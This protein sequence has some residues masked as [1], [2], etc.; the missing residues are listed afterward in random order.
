MEAIQPA[1]RRA[2]HDKGHGEAISTRPRATSEIRSGT[3]V[4]GV[5]ENRS[6]ANLPR[7]FESMLKTTTE[8][9]DI[10]LFSIKPSRVPQPLGTPRRNKGNYN[11]SEQ[12]KPRHNFQPYGVPAVDDRRRLPSYTRDASSEVISMY[13]TASQKSGSRVFD[14]PDYRSYSLTQT[15]YSSY[16]LSNHRSYASLRSQADVSNPVQRPRSPFAYPARLKRPGFRP[17]SPALTD[18]GLVDYSRRAEIERI[19]QHGSGHSTSSP[20]SLYAQRRRPHQPL[21]P[22]ANRSTPSILSQSSPNRRS[23]SPLV[24]LRNGASSHDWPRRAGPA[25]VNTSPARSTFSLASTV[26]LYANVQPRSTTTTPGK[27]PPPSPLYYDYTEDFEVEVYSESEAP[28]PPPQFRI[29]KTIPEERPMSSEGRPTGELSQQESGSN[30]FQPFTAAEVVSR[31]SS[32]RTSS[33]GVPKPKP[34]P[35][36]LRE[37]VFAVEMTPVEVETVALPADDLQDRKSVRLSGLGYGAQQLGN[38]VDEVLRLFPDSILKITNPKKNNRHAVVDLGNGKS[39]EESLE[40]FIE[41]KSARTSHSTIIN[42][43]SFPPPPKSHTIVETKLPVISGLDQSISGPSVAT[44]RPHEAFPS[45][46]EQSEIRCGQT[47]FT[48]KNFTSGTEV[49]GPGASSSIEGGP[50]GGINTS[51]SRSRSAEV[52][53]LSSTLPPARRTPIVSPTIPENLGFREAGTDRNPVPPLSLQSGRNAGEVQAMSQVQPL[54]RNQYYSGNRRMNF[55]SVT[56]EIPDCSHK[57][58]KQAVARPE[59][60][61]LAPKPISPARQLKLKN[62]VPQLMKAL[63]PLPPEPLSRPTSPPEHPVFNERELPGRFQEEPDSAL[64]QEKTEVSKKAL[65]LKI[66]NEKDKKYML[67]NSSV[68]QLK[69]EE[70][71][72]QRTAESALPLPRLKLKMKNSVPRS[73]S[74]PESRPWNLAENYNWSTQNPTLCLPAQ[75]LQCPDSKT[76]KFKLKV[77]RASNSTQGT[78]RVNRD[79]AEPRPLT[80]LQFTNPKDLFTPTLGVDNIFRQVSRHL[81]SRKTSTTSNHASQNQTTLFSKRISNQPSTSGAPAADPGIAQIL[82]TATPLSPSEARSVFSDD[83]SNVQRD[84]SLRLRGRFSNLRAR[85][86]APYAI[87]TGTQSYDDITWRDRNGPDALAPSASR[88]IPNLQDSRKSTDYARPMRRFVEKANRQKLKAKV[89]RWLKGAKSAIAARV[90]SRQQ[91]ETQRS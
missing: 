55:A 46:T 43:P 58:P 1:L 20:S 63:P 27:V 9:G 54:T 60:P 18:G 45:L 91:E 31:R 76:P 87:R 88:S 11:E 71:G 80:V 22:E 52:Q 29:D 65:S 19:P 72:A 47:A 51:E 81:H 42:I 75:D 32:T 64:T 26:N 38:H 89:H 79:S 5:I 50:V 57:I 21:R 41:P 48:S 56:D 74:P 24:S 4:Q 15:S 83:S 40:K 7:G 90:R 13:E 17:S 36:E 77:V 34:I 6:P 2:S 69:L 86:A 61:M 85:I 68:L 78:V 28:E 44:S 66:E 30:V 14:E 82:P 3:D 8:T 12:Q 49:Q 53:A 39:S 73:T 37:Q 70:K 84:H 67:E 16:T 35:S 23:S 10:G 33:D 59:S 62:S 25:S